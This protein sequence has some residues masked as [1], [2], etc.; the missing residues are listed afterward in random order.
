MSDIKLYNQTTAIQPVETLS[1]A[2]LLKGKK[3]C[4]ANDAQLDTAITVAIEKA[5]L[6]LGRQ[7]I[8]EVDNNHLCDSL[9]TEARKCFSN[10]TLLE[11]QAFINNGVRNKYSKEPVYKP[12]VILVTNWWNAGMQDAK[13]LETRQQM[14]KENQTKPEPTSDEK[15]STGKKLATDLFEMFQKNGQFG[16]SV[17]AVYEFINSLGLIDKDF[18]KGI[19]KEAL[20]QTVVE[21][22]TEIA[23][24]MDI[25]KRRRLK[26]DLEMLT[27]NI[28][29]DILTEAQHNEVLR[30]GKKIILKNWFQDLMVNEESLDDLIEG[31]RVK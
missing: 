10:L 3:V 14:Q 16:L 26:S 8:D 28:E 27:E 19:Y 25:H 21:K 20:E 30:T 4:E 17:L 7:H 5:N 23:N 12:T 6:D 22:S 31:K 15:F 29:K 11:L 1:V 9:M 2:E 18:K 24:C 13:R